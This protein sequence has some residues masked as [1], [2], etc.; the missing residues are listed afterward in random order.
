MIDQFLCL[1]FCK[2][3][4]FDVTLN[5][6]IQEGGNTTNTHCGTILCLDCCQISEVQPLNCFTGISCRSGNIISVDLSHL[7]HLIECFKLL[8]DLFTHT[9]DIII[10][11]SASCTVVSYFFCLN[12]TVDSIKG[13]TAVVT[14][15]TTTSVS[16]WKTCYNVCFSCKTHLRSIGTKNSIVVGCH[17]SSEDFFEFRIDLISVSLSSL[18]CH[19]NTAIRHECTFQR[20]VCL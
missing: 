17:I 7:L 20:F 10:H 12:Q 15:N 6:D 2:D 3:S 4:F 8:A 13:H 16:I 9:D 1:I 5:V 11:V 19:T 14:Y 18:N